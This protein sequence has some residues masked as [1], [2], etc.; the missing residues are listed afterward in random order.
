M[1]ARDSIFEPMF[2]AAATWAPSALA[3]QPELFATEATPEPDVLWSPAFLTNEEHEALFAWCR[4]EVEWKYVNLYV[5]GRNVPV[6]RGLAWFGDV[7]YAYSGLTHKARPM[8]EVLR[9]LADRIEAELA[10]N[11]TPAKFNS[12]LMNFYRDGSD[13]IGMHSDDESQLDPE[14]SIAS[15]SLGSVRKFRFQ[16]KLTRTRHETPLPGGSLLI[17]KGATQKDWRHGIPKEPGGGARANLT[18]RFTHREPVS[19]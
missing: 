1:S 3:P 9:K 17:M 6:P 18:F 11:G 8:P 19:R 5:G 16:H 15:V 13:S 14:P 10:R 2:G 7:P 12:V 4:D